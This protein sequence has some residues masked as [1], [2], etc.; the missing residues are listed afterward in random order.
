MT[1]PPTAGLPPLPE[2]SPKDAIPYEYIRMVSGYTAGFVQE[3][4]KAY[5][6]AA[7]ACQGDVVQP[8]APSPAVPDDEPTPAMCVAGLAVFGMDSNNLKP[9]RYDFGTSKLVECYKAMRRAAPPA[10]ASRVPLSDAPRWQEGMWTL[11]APDG[12]MWQADSPLK[13]CSAEQRGRIPPEVALKRIFDALDDG[14]ALT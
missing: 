6:L 13:A 3:Y 5:A 8:A 14:E 1:T 9:Q 10:P 11:T 7:I 2:I 4:A 12:R